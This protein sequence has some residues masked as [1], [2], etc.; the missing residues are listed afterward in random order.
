MSCDAIMIS[1]RIFKSGFLRHQ[2]FQ[3]KP[4]D[5]K[6]HP[7]PQNSQKQQVARSPPGQAVDGNI[8]VGNGCASQWMNV[9][10]WFSIEHFVDRVGDC[11]GSI[12]EASG[13]A[14]HNNKAE[15]GI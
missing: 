6:V 14:K 7:S 15:A 2:G 13:E 9:F 12:V 3:D 5:F 4:L 11:A 10:E 8:V 1:S